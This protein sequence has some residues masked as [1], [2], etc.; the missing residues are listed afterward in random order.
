MNTSQVNHSSKRNSPTHFLAY[1]VRQYTSVRVYTLLS[2][3]FSLSS[4]DP[5][6]RPTRGLS[7]M[8]EATKIRNDA[9]TPPPFTGSDR[10][11]RK[12]DLLTRIGHPSAISDTKVRPII[13]QSRR[14]MKDDP[15]VSGRFN[16]MTHTS[17]G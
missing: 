8:D 4:H 2:S 3:A 11:K 9:R 1:S 7:G 5:A 16:W 12:A 17:H 6:L 14:T 15:T 13:V 10:V